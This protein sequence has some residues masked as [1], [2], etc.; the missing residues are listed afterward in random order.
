MEKIAFNSSYFL[1]I[2]NPPRVYKFKFYRNFS[3][4]SLSTLPL[5]S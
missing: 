5:I 3:E 4:E 2:V 1:I